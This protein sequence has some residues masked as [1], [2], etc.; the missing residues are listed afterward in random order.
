M[1][2]KKKPAKKGTKKRPSGRH[3]DMVAALTNI[4]MVAGGVVVGNMIALKLPIQDAKMKN[5]ILIG[6][7]LLALKMIPPALAPVALG[8]SVGGALNLAGQLFPQLTAGTVQGIQGGVGRISDA[9]LRMIDEAVRRRGTGSR[10]MNG[11]TI[12]GD[13][14][15]GA[16]YM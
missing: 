12:V 10:V 1:A 16:V 7:P 4:A 8:M 9:Q 5:A 6:G 15:D 11:P 2:V 14:G 3:T 13:S